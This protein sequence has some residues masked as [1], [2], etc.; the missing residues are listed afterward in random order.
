MVLS[1]WR[2]SHLILAIVSSLFL[3]V[4]SLT[5]VILAVEPISNKVR[6]YSVDRA[7]ELT[8]T[9][10][11]TNLNSEYDEILSISRDRNGFVSVSAIIDGNNEQFYVSPF[12]G[13][14]L[15]ALIEKAPIFQFNT[16]LHRSL[17]LK[18][19]GRLLIGLVSLLLFLI[20]ISGIVLIA[21]R[22]GGIKYFFAPVVRENFSQF[23]HVVYSRITLLPIIILSLSGVYLSLLRF[24][25]IPEEQMVHEVD[26]ESLTDTP[27]TPLQNFALLSNTKLGELRELEYPFSEFVED[28]YTICL[29]DREVLMNQFNGEV[30]T[31]K[32]YPF[33]TI[34][35]SW[36]TVLHTGEG[37][38]VWSA[39]L[40]LGSLSIPFLM[41]TGF[42]IYFKRPKIR[43]KNKHAKNDCDHII[44]VGT[45]GGTTLQYA[46]EFHKQLLKTGIKSFL[47]LMNDYSEYKKMTQLTIFT[48]TYGQGEAPISA[49]RFME[50]AKETLQT[51]PFTFSVIGF[52]STAYPNYCKFAYETYETLKGLSNAKGL[53]EVH[54][55]ND[56]SFEAFSNW[57]NRWAQTM[58]LT[59]QLEKP[60]I[61]LAKN[62]VSDFEVIHRSDL[63][64]ENTFLLT[65]KDVKGKRAVSGDLLSITPKEDGRERLYSIGKLG[66]N[67]L[68]ISVKK[69]PNGIC[70]NLL[71]QLDKGQV[72]SAAVAKNRHF[73]P[74]KNTKDVVLIATGTGIGPFLGMIATNTPK[75]KMHLYWGGRTPQS[76]KLYQPYIDEAQAKKKLQSFTPAYSRVQ[77]KKVYVQHLIKK[78]GDKVA[79]IL[80]KGGAVMICGS[81]A[82]QRE[83]MNELQTICKSYL[84]KDL[85]YYQNKGQI[86]MDCY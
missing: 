63:E 5:G 72:L 74:P 69:Y 14:R 60:K 80:N 84:A 7:D 43:I 65:L 82:M 40:G 12:T 56:Q 41:L 61:S 21:K 28:Y 73:H 44:L 6:P 30:I 19:P 18:T 33:M 79:E 4:A 2:Y 32:K 1:V 54:T 27:N 16:N 47:G 8:L 53:G 66:R 31:E 49:N 11:L 86:K 81:I 67:T 62:Q 37:S 24:E 13:E 38:I 15:G 68:A 50:L 70:S 46:Q 39:I 45:E 71:G 76:F 35:S 26:Y 22:Q 42:I 59:L 9:E 77:T 36:A 55:V 25:L 10:T 64:E 58:G 48:A 75:R 52:G 78:D 34:A 20:A 17:F 57:A 51:Q 83:I 3:L 23:N 85:S 29:K